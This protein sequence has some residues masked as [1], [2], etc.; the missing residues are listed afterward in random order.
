MY[1][2]IPVETF[3]GAIELACYGFTTMAALITFLLTLR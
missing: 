1:P 2:I 3:S